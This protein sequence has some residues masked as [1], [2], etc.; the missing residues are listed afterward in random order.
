MTFKLNP[1]LENSTFLIKD[2]A[3]SQ[4][5]LSKNSLITWFLLVPKTDIIEW[6]LLDQDSQQRLNN[7]ICLISR[8]LKEELN[9]DKINVATIGNVVAQMHI[10]VVGRHKDDCFWPDVIWGKKEFKEYTKEQFENLK[11]K[12]LNFI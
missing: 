10:H 3:D 5:L 12:F 7:Q 1:I 4:I 6:Y 2:F 8:F 9:C 11:D